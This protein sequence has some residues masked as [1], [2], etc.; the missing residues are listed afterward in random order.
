MTTI[1]K[2]DIRRWLFK[3]YQNKQKLSHMLIV[4]DRMY[5][6]RNGYPIYVKKTENVYDVIDCISS[7]LQQIME[8]Y[9]ADLDIEYQL[10]ELFTWHT[11]KNEKE[12]RTMQESFNRLKELRRD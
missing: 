11:E 6:Y 12:N 2:N 4:W 10:N 1:T 3:L 7:P 9:S 5:D 8:V